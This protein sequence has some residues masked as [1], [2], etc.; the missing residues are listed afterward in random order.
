MS[1][2]FQISIILWKPAEYFWDEKKHHNN[3]TDKILVHFE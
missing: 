3:V 1:T 2:I